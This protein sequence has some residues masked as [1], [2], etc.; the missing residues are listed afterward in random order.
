MELKILDLLGEEIYSES[1]PV[2]AKLT[3]LT[4][5]GHLISPRGIFFCHIIT[6]NDKI[7]RK[8]VKP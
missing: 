7:T 5:N 4:W 2:R 6:G 3:D 1:L 8:V